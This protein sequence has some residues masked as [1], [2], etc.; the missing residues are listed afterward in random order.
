M[1]EKKVLVVDDEKDAVECL[2]AILEGNGYAVLS[3]GDGTEGIAKAKET[4]PD[5]ILL[6]VQM[7]GEDGFHIFHKMR[8]DEEL[9]TI[10]VVMV[11]GI[12]QK[13]GI[14]FSADDMEEFLHVRP[15]G[16]IEKPLDPENVIATIE[17]ILT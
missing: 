11:T 5:I 1:N 4:Q 6:D 17:E 2:K 3:A 8:H 14:K 15:E 10:P 16:Y 13:T 12:A 7:P 9:K